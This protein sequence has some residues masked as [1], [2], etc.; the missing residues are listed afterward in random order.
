MRDDQ[1][2]EI[3]RVFGLSWDG[4]RR[5][6]RGV[7][8]SLRVHMVALGSRS[9]KEYLDRLERSREEREEAQRLMTV[10]ISRFFRDKDLWRALERGVLPDLARTVE[11]RVR[12]WSA[13]CACGEEAYSL[14]IVWQSL[15]DRRE[16][17]ADLE[18]WATDANP[19]YLEKARAGI[20]G[21]SSLKELPDEWRAAYFSRIPGQ[22]RFALS[23]P[24]KEGIR[25]G[26]H[27]LVRQECPASGF[28]LIFLRNNLLT[29][30][31]G[32]Q[33]HTAFNGIVECLED[34]GILIIGSHEH[35]P[36]TR[37]SMKRDPLC[38]WI[39]WA[40]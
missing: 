12:A 4:Y 27:D 36:P 16:G 23:G 11:G 35:L 7:K 8:K 15:D 38:P 9:V 32:Q 34:G 19:S 17:P 2:R 20:Y 14:R 13:G 25:W 39:Y 22:D 1:F 10:S 6:R 21:P 24:L 30:Y 28:D 37:R 3:L 5:V 40:G 26:V 29:Y 18:L 31:Q 33:M